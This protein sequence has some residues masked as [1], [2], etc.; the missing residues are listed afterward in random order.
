MGLH[1]KSAARCRDRQRG[2]GRSRRPR[3]DRRRSSGAGARRRP[4]TPGARGTA[5]EG[6][7]AGA[8]RRPV[9]GKARAPRPAAWGMG[10]RACGLLGGVQPGPR[11]RLSAGPPDP[12]SQA[13]RR[14]SP[15]RPGS[16]S[17]CPS[18][19][20]CLCSDSTWCSSPPRRRLRVALRGAGVTFKAGGQARGDAGGGGATPGLGWG[21]GRPLGGR[22]GGSGGSVSGGSGSAGGL[23]WRGG[24]AVSCHSFIAL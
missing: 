20:P 5:R 13:P 6:G 23:R 10:G 22:G 15:E 19:C 11:V 14:D 7:R 8:P 2:P 18:G 4:R 1:P 9:A 16:A 21:A 12:G 24:S 3:G 17:W